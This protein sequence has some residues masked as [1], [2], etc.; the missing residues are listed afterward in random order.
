M[1]FDAD[2][3]RGKGKKKGKTILVP[4]L[5]TLSKDGIGSLMA[6]EVRVRGLFGPTN[7]NILS[8]ASIFIFFFRAEL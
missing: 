2:R 4:S 6:R 7:R 1:C 5:S 3:E 8:T